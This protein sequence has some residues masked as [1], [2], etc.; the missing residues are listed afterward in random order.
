MPAFP[1]GAMVNLNLDVSLSQIAADGA[2]VVQIWCTKNEI[3]PIRFNVDVADKLLKRCSML[4]LKISALCGDTGLGFTDPAKGKQALELTTAY[5]EV[6]QAL[7]VTVLTSHIGYFTDAASR[8]TALELLK[9]VGDEG[10]K[11]NVTFA[12]ETGAEDGPTLRAFLDE[13]NHPRIKVNFDPANMLMRGFDL[14]EAVRLLAKDI[15]HSHAK[16]GLPGGEIVLG[17]GGVPWPE[18][19][20]WLKQGGYT[21]PLVVEREGGQ[22]Q[23]EDVRQAM[24]L[25]KKWRGSVK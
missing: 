6:C 20:G 19:L 11:R 18:Y 21:G 13:L 24:N 23:R 25:L 2:E 4:G 9:R 3:A 14:H 8:K 16:D 7:G 17:A 5:F 22:T 10:A 1:I 12:T 15:V